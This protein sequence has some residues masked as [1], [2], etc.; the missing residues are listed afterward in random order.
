MISSTYFNSILSNFQLLPEQIQEQVADYVE[1]LVLK[2]SSS[3]PNNK[4]L[5]EIY[6]HSPRQFG[7]FK[8]KIKLSKDFNEPMEDFKEY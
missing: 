8:G 6:I 7:V 1:F 5:D 2:Y 3:E 4:N